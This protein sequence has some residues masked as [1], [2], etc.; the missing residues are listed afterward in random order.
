MAIGRSRTQFDAL[1]TSVEEF[2]VA[3]TAGEVA[4]LVRRLDFGSAASPAVIFCRLLAP[5]QRRRDDTRFGRLSPLAQIRWDNRIQVAPPPLAGLI[6][7][8]YPI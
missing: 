5:D 1:A 7:A 6:T 4:V 2:K 8:G 3:I